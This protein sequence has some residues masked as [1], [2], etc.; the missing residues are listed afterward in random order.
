M[1]LHLRCE[2]RSRTGTALRLSATQLDE[3]RAARPFIGHGLHASDR[4]GARISD[5]TTFAARKAAISADKYPTSPRI[6]SVCAPSAGPI[7]RVAPGVSDSLGT[8]PGNLIGV[9]SGSLCCSNI[10]RAW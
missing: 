7:Q 6:S 8:I 10:L 5:Q 3:N 1:S 4:L 2:L 9:P